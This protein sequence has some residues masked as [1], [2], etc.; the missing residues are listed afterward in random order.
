MAKFRIPEFGTDV[1]TVKSLDYMS[2][3]DAVEITHRSGIDPFMAV[4]THSAGVVGLLLAWWQ[5]T[6]DS[7]EWRGITW[8]E[9]YESWP[10]GVVTTFKPDADAADVMAAA[11]E[12]D[13]AEA[14][15]DHLNP[16]EAMPDFTGQSGH[17]SGS[18]P[19]GALPLT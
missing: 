4:N 10:A 19:P 14:D 15:A 8:D 2:G 6:N 7:G 5:V 12:L 13:H 9:V 3:K 1:I 18:P 17:G 11:A 16:D